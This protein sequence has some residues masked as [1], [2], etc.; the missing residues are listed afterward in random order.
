[1]TP[2]AH[3]RV[4][5]LVSDVTW[6]AIRPVPIRRRGEPMRD[7]ATLDRLEAILEDVERL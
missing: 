4:R 2:A 5:T 1:M 7:P 6:E 3:P